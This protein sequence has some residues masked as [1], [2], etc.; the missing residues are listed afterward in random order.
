MKFMG[1]SKMGN[2]LKNGDIRNRSK[3]LASGVRI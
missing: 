1:N 2:N 3:C